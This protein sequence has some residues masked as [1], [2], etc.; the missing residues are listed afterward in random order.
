VETAIARIVAGDRRGSLPPLAVWGKAIPRITAGS[1]RIRTNRG[2]RAG[3]PR[4]HPAPAVIL[5]D[6]KDLLAAS[7]EHKQIVRSAQ[8]DNTAARP[9]PHPR[10]S[11]AIRVVA[12]PRTAT[13]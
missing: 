10:A 8:D 9:V 13:I 3:S 6:A 11:A 7:R 2:P 5:S 1:P 4:C 12:L